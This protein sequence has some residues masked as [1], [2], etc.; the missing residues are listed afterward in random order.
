MKTKYHVSIEFRYNDSPVGEFDSTCKNKTLTIG[1]F[2][3]QEEAIDQGNRTLEFLEARFD[4]NVNYNQ[5][6]RF[7]K[8]GGCFGQSLTLITNLGYLQTPFEFYASITKLEYSENKETINEV[9]D[10]ILQA[11]E[12]YIDYK[13]LNKE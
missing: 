9:L 8:T 13:K 3:S 6:R 2:D 1:I 5:K 4:L 10:N 11:R 7:S 12:R